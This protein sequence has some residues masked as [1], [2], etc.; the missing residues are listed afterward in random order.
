MKKASETMVLSVILILAITVCALAWPVP[1]TGQTKCY[2][3]QGNEITCPAPGEDFY[4]QDGNYTINPPS[5]TKLDAQGNDLPNDA[6][7]W[8]MVRD[9]VTGL[10]WEVKQA[11]DDVMDYSNPHDADNEYTWYD[12]NP[13]TN[14]GVAGTSGDVPDT[15]DFINALNAESFGGYSDWRLPAIKELTYVENLGRYNPVIDIAY[16]SNVK[17]SSYWSSS[18]DANNPGNVWIVDFSYADDYLYPKSGNWY[19]QAVR[20]EQNRNSEHWMINGDGTITDTNTGLMWQRQ[21]PVLEIN[22]WKKVLAYCENLLL[23]GYEDWRLPNREELRSIVAYEKYSPAIV[24]FPDTASNF[25]WSS[26]SVTNIPGDAYV[27]SFGDG[28]DS[29]YPKSSVWYV[30]AVRGGQNQS[31]EHLIISLPAQASIWGLGSVMPITWD[32]QDTSENVG[33]SVSYQAGKDGTYETIAETTEN[34][35]RY[36]WTVTGPASVNCMLKIEPLNDPSKG[37]TQGFFTITNFP[38]T[39]S[40]PSPSDQSSDIP[41][42]SVLS[43]IGGDPDEKDTVTYDIYLGTSDTPTKIASRHTSTTYNPGSLNYTT[44]YYWKVVAMDNHGTRSEGPVWHFTTRDEP[45]GTI[46]V[47]I[48]LPEATYTLTGPAIYNGSGISWSKTDAVIGEYTVTYNS[49]VCWESPLSE[50]QILAENE[51]ITFTGDYTITETPINAHTTPPVQ[52]WSNNNT[53]ATSWTAGSDCGNGVAGYSYLWDTSAT[54]EPDNTVDTSEISIS[55]P[56]L[57][58]GDNHY[59]HVCAVDESGNKSSTLHIGPF[60][61]D[62]LPP[63]TSINPAGGLYDSPQQLTFICD[64]TGSGCDKIFYT[65]DESEP[66]TASSSYSEAI[67]IDETAILKFFSVDKTGNSGQVETEIYTIDDPNPPTTSVHPAGGFL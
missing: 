51:T 38:D 56:S 49:V 62:T 7:E 53:V 5:Y 37:T 36:D 9:N 39:P 58:D 40:D 66:T 55:G 29:R 31:T 48:N 2:D 67:P 4:G 8:V 54:T 15:E 1:D 26:S 42:E 41:S 17:P 52:T 6:T 32:V 25:Y 44:T 34:D 10:I 60:L 57:P 33:I 61:I 18:S 63:E 16:F 46:L 35:G 11:K 59:L 13:E 64:D 12:S 28:G 20:G 27:I 65:T 21:A 23:G 45:T 22:T 3:D 47:N 24:Y 30:R 14:G 43:W 19:V 50:V